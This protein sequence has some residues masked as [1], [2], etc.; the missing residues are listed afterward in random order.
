MEVLKHTIF[1]K[2]IVILF[3]I[4]CSMFSLYKLIR[5]FDEGDVK[6]HVMQFKRPKVVTMI[7]LQQHGRY[8]SLRK[9]EE[10]GERLFTW[11]GKIKWNERRCLLRK[12][13][14]VGQSNNLQ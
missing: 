13:G 4:H 2:E 10:K 5:T 11:L 3:F 9:R 7:L 6:M 14:E 8:Q 12:K 1:K